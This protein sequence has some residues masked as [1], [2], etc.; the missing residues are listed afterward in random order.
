[1]EVSP[2]INFVVGKNIFSFT[3]LRCC[4]IFLLLMFVF[5]VT[6]NNCALIAFASWTWSGF[7]LPSR[8]VGVFSKQLW[9]EDISS[10]SRQQG[11]RQKKETFR[12]TKR[13][14]QDSGNWKGVRH[15]SGLSDGC[16]VL[17][18]SPECDEFHFHKKHCSHHVWPGG[19]TAVNIAD[20]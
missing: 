13:K 12:A 10:R 11:G 7:P 18:Q 19:C 1:M 6:V 9:K 20:V 16:E 5:I 4:L 17:K 14:E 8:S 15:G 3:Y 2:T